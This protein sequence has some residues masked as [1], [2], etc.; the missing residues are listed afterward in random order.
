MWVPP[1]KAI[2]ATRGIAE[3]LDGTMCFAEYRKLAGFL[4]SVLFMLGDDKSLMN[5]IFRP[6]QHNAEAA[7]FGLPTSGWMRG[8]PGGRKNIFLRD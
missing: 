2:K 6:M 1:A 8:W 4:I 3:V 5:H 7:G